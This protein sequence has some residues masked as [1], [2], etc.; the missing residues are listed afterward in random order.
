M[1]ERLRPESHATPRTAC[2]SADRDSR[3]EQLLLTGL[4]HYFAGEYERA[5]SAW[6][7]VLFI[8]RGHARAKAYI[9]R[10]RGAIAERQRE[11]EELLHRGVA[12][13]NRGETEHARGCCYVRRRARRAAGSGAGVPRTAGAPR[14]G[15]ARSPSRLPRPPAAAASAP[16]AAAARAPRAAALAPGCSRSLVLAASLVGGFYVQDSR[17]RAAPFLFLTETASGTAPVPPGWRRNRCRCRGAAELDL[18]RA[19]A[20]LASGHPRDALRLVER[21]RPGR[22][23]ARARPT[24]LRDDIQRALLA[25]VR[26][27]QAP[28]PVGPAASGQAPRDPMKC[29]KCGYIGFEQTDRC[30]NCGYDFSL[31]TEVAPT[32]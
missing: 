30:R 24:Q 25:G 15:R 21:V 22:P 12:A 29:P 5:I 10:A 6:T 23:L 9:D 4:D 3:I 19:R 26:W 27:R 32:T 18:A 28:A 8:D 7:R 1:P 16:R 2:R 31:A 14:R 11:S 13:F 20:L 17:E